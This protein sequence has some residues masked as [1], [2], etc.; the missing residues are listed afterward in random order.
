MLHLIDGREQRGP[1]HIPRPKP[2]SGDA[3]PLEVVKGIV[4][5]VKL[6]GDQAV[7]AY[8]AR[9]DGVNLT[10]E[11]LRVPEDKLAK[12][13]SLVRPELVEALEVMAE[14]L[15][16]TCERQKP[17]SWIERR[18]DEFVG[19]LF[20]PLRRVGAY[21]PGGRASYPS[22]VLMTAIPARVAGVEGIA[23]ASPPGPN[24]EISENV[25]AACA[26]AGVTEV[27]R[28][29]GAQAIAALAYG[30]ESIRP[31][32]KVV[33]PGN[34]YVA[35]AKR[36]V[37]GWVGIDSE[38]GPTEL[39]IVA[40]SSVNPEWLAL[41][42]I[43][44]AEHGP[45]GSHVL[46][47]WEPDL[48][49]AVGVALDRN[50]MMHEHPND[51]E[52]HLIEGG[53]A[54]LVRDLAHALETA[55]AFAP[56]HLELIFDGAED[57]LDEITDAGSVFVGP[58]SPVPVGDYVGGTNHVLPTGGTAR[59]ASA[60]GVADFLKRMYVSGYEESALRRLAP[61]IDSLA[62]AEGLPGHAR[63]VWERLGPE[64]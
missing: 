9:Y 26:I 59:Y 39:A 17:E 34:I 30:T 53:A 16:T 10:P 32:R 3:E 38:A 21:V 36:L 44:Q 14:R 15:G 50:V 11:D 8:S 13:T 58:Y 33:G 25:L 42:L 60:L 27:Y 7:L 6:R 48:I 19:E 49:E 1:V 18:G 45:L 4:E 2:I 64:R 23:V 47:T 12:A 57:H 40:D 63:A 24:G 35:L 41:D 56:E 52:N 55:N 37:Q 29:G 31:V 46:I 51:I 62:E 20:R 22:S 54:V 43:A 61:H 5:D 28:V